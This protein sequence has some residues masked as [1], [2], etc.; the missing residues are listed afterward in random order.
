MSFSNVVTNGK[1]KLVLPLTWGK[2]Q[3]AHCEKT[4]ICRAWLLLGDREWKG[5]GPSEFLAGFTGLNMI[6]FTKMK[7]TGEMVNV[8]LHLLYMFLKM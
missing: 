4:E 3:C 6:C 8:V 2:K 5:K 7:K 1:E